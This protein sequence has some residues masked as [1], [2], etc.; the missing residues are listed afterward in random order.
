MSQPS[1]QEALEVELIRSLFEAGRPPVIMSAGFVAAGGLIA[2]KT[3]DWILI[4]LLVAGTVAS[5]VR[6]LLTKFSRAEAAGSDLPARRARLLERRFAASY[7][8]FATILG[9]FAY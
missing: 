9:M 8:A 5:L 6:L 3:Q 2:W 7:L 1:Q 4:L